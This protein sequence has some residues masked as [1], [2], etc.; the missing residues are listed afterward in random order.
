[1]KGMIKLGLLPTKTNLMKIQKSI[2]LSK[3]GQEL[4]D[5]KKYILMREKEKYIGQKQEI[6]DKFSKAYNKAFNLLRNCNVDIGANKVIEVAKKIEEKG[7]LDIKYTTIM[8]V[9]IPSVIYEP[10]K[11][12]EMP[13]GLLETTISIDRAIEAF[14]E[15]K[16]I[17]IKLAEIEVTINRLNEA[18]E[19]VQ[20]RA[21]S[22][23]N[24]IIPHDEKIEK[25]ISDVLEEREREEFSRMKM[26]KSN[27]TSA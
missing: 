20:T 18:I 19:K 10:S 5:K 16:I 24:I 25:Q 4:L 6:E 9:D 7:K 15:L 23:K 21:N 12:T 13:Y 26:I 27:T 22:L 11:N 8:G 14:D 2:A 3:Q 17:L 1:M